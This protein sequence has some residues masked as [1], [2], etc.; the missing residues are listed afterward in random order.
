VGD[1][2]SVTAKVFAILEAFESGLSSL[3]LS[4]IADS[5]GLPL[6]TAHRLA[7]EL[8]RW[9]ALE[10]DGN[11]RYGV[12]LRL[13]EVAQN[14]GRQLRDSARPHLQDLF[15]L[16]QETAHLAV[17][18]GHEALYIDRVYSSK[19]VPRASRVGGRLPLHATAVGKVLLA[20]EDDWLQEAYVA[21]ALEAPTER[22]HINPDRLRQ[23]LQAIRREGYATTF[24]EVRLGACSIAVPVFGTPGRAA[25]AVGLVMLSTQAPHMTRHLPV[26]RGIARRIEPAVGRWPIREVLTAEGSRKTRRR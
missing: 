12:G 11:G 21:R 16:T 15:L 20:Y 26:L 17:R 1:G 23:E 3:S 5:A 25:A 24:E 14:A 6:P 10:R 13:W 2:R 9:G 4:Q 18:E 7:G 22:T 19:R 8:V